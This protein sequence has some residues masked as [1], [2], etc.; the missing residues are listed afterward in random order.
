MVVLDD[1]REVGAGRPDAPP[2]PGP[3][4]RDEDV[5]VRGPV[6]AGARV[7]RPIDGGWDVG[8][9]ADGAGLVFSLSQEEKKSSEDSA[10]PAV[11]VDA[12]RGVSSRPSIWI[13]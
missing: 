2:A 4:R 1:N 10:A 8:L 11:G 13:P 9:I 7:A 12:A 5:T 3:E 6:A